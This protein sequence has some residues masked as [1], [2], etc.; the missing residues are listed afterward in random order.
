M[1]FRVTLV[2]TEE[3]V[4]ASCPSLRGCHSQGNTREEALANIR[5]AIREWLDAEELERAEFKIS[6]E[7]V[8]V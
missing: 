7:I 1:E 2:E 8:T 3:G 4:A 6:E 5:V